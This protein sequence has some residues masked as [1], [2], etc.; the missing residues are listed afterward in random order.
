M[1]VFFSEDCEDYNRSK[2]IGESLVAPRVGSINSLGLFQVDVSQAFIDPF[3]G[4]RLL[5]RRAKP[6]VPLEFLLKGDI[7]AS[8][9]TSPYLVKSW[10]L[11]NDRAGF[12]NTAVVS[13]SDPRLHD[14]YIYE[15]P[16]YR[17]KDKLFILQENTKGKYAFIKDVNSDGLYSVEKKYL[18]KPPTSWVGSTDSKTRGSNSGGVYTNRHGESIR[19]EFKVIRKKAPLDSS[20][21][22]SS[23]KQISVVKTR[24]N[25]GIDKVDNS[26]MYKDKVEGR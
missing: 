5:Y 16:D 11:D 20:K 3:T 4:E 9:K 18:V 6:E 10:W 8:G 14:Y 1:A 17:L 21:Y 22:Y 24:R 15:G 13:T 26:W 19:R 12:N 23:G 7:T 2:A 25:R